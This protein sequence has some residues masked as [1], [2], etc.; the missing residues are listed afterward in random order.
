[1]IAELKLSIVEEMVEGELDTYKLTLRVVDA[2][3]IDP[4]IFVIE[5]SCPTLNVNKVEES[6]HHVAYL[7]EL[8]TIGT[9]VKTTT[10]QY[11][12]KS[13]I[14]RTYGTLQ[15]MIESKKVM[16]DDVQKLLADNNHFGEK[17]KETTVTITENSCNVEQ[18]VGDVYTFN[19]ETINF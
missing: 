2:V 1:M 19:G 18:V 11:I 16:L 13:S 12:R 8:D 10:H 5:R 6:F 14:T 4:N 9:T 7:H 3:N 15:R 17:K